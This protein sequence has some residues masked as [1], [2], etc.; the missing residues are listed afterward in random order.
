[1]DYLDRITEVNDDRLAFIDSGLV[2]VERDLRYREIPLIY[3]SMQVWAIDRFE[4]VS[5]LFST[6]MHY[7]TTIDFA[8]FGPGGSSPVP[9]S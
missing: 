8:S 2:G 6:A 1:M 7:Y 4:P 9:V 5:R 3:V